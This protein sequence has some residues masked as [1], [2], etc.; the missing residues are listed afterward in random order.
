MS[1]KTVAITT[2]TNIFKSLWL[3]GYDDKLYLIVGYE[4]YFVYMALRRY[5]MIDQYNKHASLHT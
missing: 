2:A 5:T 4:K 1:Y 3:G